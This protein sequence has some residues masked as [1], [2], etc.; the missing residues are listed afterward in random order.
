[1]Q[2]QIWIP[3]KGRPGP[4]FSNVLQKA[5]IPHT[6]WIEPQEE[7]AYRT[8]TSNPL[9]TFKILEKND[10]GIAYVRQTMLDE[11]RSKKMKVFIFDD[12]IKS[13]YEMLPTQNPESKTRKKKKVD[14]NLA[15]QRSE[16]VFVSEGLAYGSFV[17]SIF[18]FCSKPGLAKNKAD[19]AS[20]WLDGEKIPEDINYD[21]ASGRE[22][23]YFVT[24]L[25]LS[26]ALCGKYFDI[27]VNHSP[28]ANPGMK[29][30]LVDWYADW[31]NVIVA[32]N[33]WK[34]SLERKKEKMLQELPTS[35]AAKLK[36]K[37]LYKSKT[38]KMGT[39][40]GLID[41]SP[42]WRNIAALRNAYF[43]GKLPPI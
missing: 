1:M 9:V 36:D 34:E 11:C 6:I 40:K 35:V 24:N 8:A 37:L 43:Q 19:T 12:D 4:Y 26:G 3:S 31:Q 42:N 27:A 18:A 29:G 32:D 10:Q 7:N 25:M 16:E 28:V 33:F 22:D 21:K 23:L 2:S 5:K 13:F 41:T 15:L 39:R 30:G 38:I 17:F 14:P 20:I